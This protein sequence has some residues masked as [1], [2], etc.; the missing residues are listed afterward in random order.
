MT[1]QNKD[2]TDTLDDDALISCY[3]VFRMLKLINGN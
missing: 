2:T 1:C 3:Q